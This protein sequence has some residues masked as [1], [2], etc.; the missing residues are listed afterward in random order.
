MGTLSHITD[1]GLLLSFDAISGYLLHK[2]A[3]SSHHFSHRKTLAEKSIRKHGIS[4][5][6]VVII[7]TSPTI[8]N[9]M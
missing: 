7:M 3:E 8:C 5:R 9:Q 1:D 2:F 6:K 4:R